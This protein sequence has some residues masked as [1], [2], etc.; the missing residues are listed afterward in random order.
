MGFQLIGAMDIDRCFFPFYVKVLFV[1]RENVLCPIAS[2]IF[3]V[4]LSLC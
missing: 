3:L 2:L 1:Q 4:P